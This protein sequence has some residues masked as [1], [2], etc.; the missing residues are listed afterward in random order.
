MPATAGMDVRWETGE[1]NLDPS[2]TH[3]PHLGVEWT[4]GACGLC[5]STAGAQGAHWADC[6]LPP[7]LSHIHLFL[8]SLVTSSLQEFTVAVPRGEDSL[9]MKIATKKEASVLK[10]SG[11][12]KDVVLPPPPPQR[13]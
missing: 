9:G 6:T 2:L 5:A 10:G 12:T 4:A 7:V 11:S 13:H 1:E 3:H 8:R